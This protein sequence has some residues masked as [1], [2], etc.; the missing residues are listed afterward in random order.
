MDTGSRPSIARVS[1]YRPQYQVASIGHC[2][3]F[4]LRHIPEASSK[5]R[6]SRRVA[7]IPTIVGVWVL[8]NGVLGRESQRANCHVETVACARS[9]RGLNLDCEATWKFYQVGFASSG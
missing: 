6:G 2:G 5:G 8:Q 7:R 4:L 1:I 9:E 3:A